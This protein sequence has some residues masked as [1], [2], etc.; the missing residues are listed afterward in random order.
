MANRASLLVSAT[1]RQ[2]IA[3]THRRR[4]TPYLPLPR[5]RECCTLAERWQS[6]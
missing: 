6:G 3:P 2:A 4:Y 5:C 1:D